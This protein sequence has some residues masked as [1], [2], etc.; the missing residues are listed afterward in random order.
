MKAFAYV[1]AANQKDALA[2]LS[3]TTSRGKVLPIAGGMDLLGLMKDYIAQPDVLVNVKHLS[4]TIAV[5]P[6]GLSVIGA[7][8]RLLSGAIGLAFSMRRSSSHST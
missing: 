2:A 3:T 7:A 1:N 6:Q 8:T 5:E 4:S